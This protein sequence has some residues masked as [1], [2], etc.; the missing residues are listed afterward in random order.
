MER[1]VLGGSLDSGSIGFIVW[2]KKNKN[3]S[4]R[5]STGGDELDCEWL[6]GKPNFS[7]R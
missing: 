3:N 5:V 6:N 1:V 7:V 2:K 4:E